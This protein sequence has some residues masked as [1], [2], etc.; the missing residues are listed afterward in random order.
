MALNRK[1]PDLFAKVQAGERRLEALKQLGYTDIP[2]TRVDL[3]D[4]VRGEFAENFVRKDF[5]PSEEVAICEA[6]EPLEAEKAKERQER[7]PISGGKL[8]Q[9]KRVKHATK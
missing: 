6:I 1:R 4:I 7:K 2:V 3:E 9:Q 5:V 8:P